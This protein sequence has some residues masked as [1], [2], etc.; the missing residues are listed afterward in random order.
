M[1][2]L[3]PESGGCEVKVDGQVLARHYVA[4]NDLPEA[5]WIAVF[6]TDPFQSADRD[7]LLDLIKS[8]GL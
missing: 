3:V 5:M 2:N 4:G 1:S 8:A 7:Y 6:M